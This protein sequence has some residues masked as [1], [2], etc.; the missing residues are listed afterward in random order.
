M[1]LNVKKTNQL[2]NLFPKILIM[3]G[4]GAG[5]TYFLASGNTKKTLIISVKTE[6]G[7]MTLHDLEI[8]YVEIESFKDIQEI[9]NYLKSPENKY[10]TVGLDSLTQLQ[11][12]LIKNDLKGMTGFEKWAQVKELTFEIVQRFKSLPLN[13]IFICESDEDKDDKTGEI[14]VYPRLVG[15]SKQTIAHWFDEVY[16]F[17]RIEE[18]DNEGNKSIIYTALTQS[19]DKYPCKSRIGTLPRV[20]VNP[21]LDKIINQLKRK[22]TPKG[23]T[24]NE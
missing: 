16:Y 20:I 10:E 13:A 7:L 5:K 23:G 9:Y 15:K 11:E 4:S 1:P 6:A 14:K 19:G 3:G 17:K 21:E 18:I 8:D 12:C 24:K 2:E 22:P